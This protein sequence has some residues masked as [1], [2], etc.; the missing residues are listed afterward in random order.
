MVLMQSSS[1]ARELATALAKQVDVQPSTLIRF[2]KEFGYSG[3][4]PMQ[5]IFKLRLIEGAPVYREKIY[6][7]KTDTDT[8]PATST[9]LDDCADARCH[10]FDLQHFAAPVC[11]HCRQ[12]S[13]I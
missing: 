13:E 1:R 2:A 7:E 10:S 5:Q 8:A 3:F 4:S 11:G 6:E 12:P 9:I